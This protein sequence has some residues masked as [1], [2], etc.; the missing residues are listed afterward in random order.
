M[1]L[2]YSSRLESAAISATYCS[3][4]LGSA[5]IIAFVH[6]ASCLNSSK[7]LNQR[8]LLNVEPAL[9]PMIIIV[10]S[11]CAS[12]F[13]GMTR[14]VGE[15]VKQSRGDGMASYK[16]HSFAKVSEWY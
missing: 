4:E 7:Q 3:L 10:K 16:F 1:R 15:G 6:I 13:K 5:S 2:L 11:F 8:S 14:K 9:H 12:D